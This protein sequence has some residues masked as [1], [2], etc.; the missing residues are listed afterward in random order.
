[1]FKKLLVQ[2]VFYQNLMRT[3]NYSQVFLNSKL[4]QMSFQKSLFLI[5]IICIVF[6]TF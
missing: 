3:N 5:G 2:E 6:L 1:M 4:S